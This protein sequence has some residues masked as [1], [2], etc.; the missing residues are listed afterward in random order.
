MIAPSTATARADQLRGSISRV[1]WES[2]PKFIASV[3]VGGEMVSVV[4]SRHP[5]PRPGSTLVASGRWETHPKFGR[6]FRAESIDVA[7]PTDERGATKMLATIEGVGPATALRIYRELGPDAYR[8]VSAD[9]AILKRFLSR[10]KA[11]AAAAAFAQETAFD[12]ARQKLYS[13][14]FGDALV[15]GILKWFADGDIDDVLARNPYALV[16][17]PRVSFTM[18]DDGLMAAQRFPVDSAFRAAAAVVECLKRAAED[19]G[20]TWL[21]LGEIKAA[22]GRL[23]LKHP[24]PAEALDAGIAAAVKAEQVVRVEGTTGLA[25]PLI[26][27]DEAF[28]AARILEMCGGR[29]S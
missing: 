17:V 3:E 8:L 6:Q 26:A 24:I 29:K 19:D 9:P 7:A 13:L 27:A 23:K 12:E 18:V 22:L 16:S 10:A 11:D 28:V 2:D 25:F 1:V 15:A 5:V 4:G 14:G 21:P 20:H